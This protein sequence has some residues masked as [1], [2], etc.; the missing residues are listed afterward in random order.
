MKTATI[1]TTTLVSFVALASPALATTYGSVE[2]SAS[3]DVIDTTPLK[4]VR[5]DVRAAFAERLLQCGIVNQVIEVLISTGSIKTI[6]GL[7]THLEV[8]AGGFAGATNPSY[9][10]TIMDSGPNAASHGD[11]SILIDSLGY[12]LS[13][14]SAFLLDADNATS[15]DFPAN[16]VV[17]N[18]DTPPALKKSA[19]LFE[20]VGQIDRELFATDSSGYTQFG[21]AYLSLQSF[22]ENEQ[23][24][25]GYLQ[26]ATEFGVEYTPID[27]MG[28]PGL[29]EGGRGVSRQQL[30]PEPQR[31]GVPRTDSGGK[32]SFAAEASFGPS[33]IHAR[34]APPRRSTRRRELASRA[35]QSDGSA[36]VSE[37]SIGPLLPRRASRRT[38][39]P[40]SRRATP[41]TAASEI[42]R[43]RLD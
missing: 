30:G 32:P 33:S 9:V 38:R 7:N 23:F 29:F 37:R 21:R 36:Q 18:F 28:T 27:S 11:I 19:A 5:L 2:P 40:V 25:A 31:R 1:L 15:F 43:A 39:E 16:Y 4:D 8:G 42:S 26:A 12:V 6:N 17:L 20:T 13:Q 24:I 35:A 3:V 41:V 34:C 22:V 10:F 14:S